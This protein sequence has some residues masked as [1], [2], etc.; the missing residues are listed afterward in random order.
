MREFREHEEAPGLLSPVPFPLQVNRHRKRFVHTQRS[1]VSCF[2]YLKDK[3][4]EQEYS[5]RD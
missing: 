2:V 5:L 1:I 3:P 4:S